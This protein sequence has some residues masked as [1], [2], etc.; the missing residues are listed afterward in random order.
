M[1]NDYHELWF[2]MYKQD[3]GSFFGSYPNELHQWF[4]LQGKLPMLFNS[5]QEALQYAINESLIDCTPI[6]WADYS[7]SLISNKNDK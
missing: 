5:R 6:L 7:S 1:E 4:V 2:L 3:I